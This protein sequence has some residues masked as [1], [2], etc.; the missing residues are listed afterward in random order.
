MVR[1]WEWAQ[2]LH[3]VGKNYLYVNRALGTFPPGRWYCPPEV[4]AITLV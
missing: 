3:Q 4:T 2:G 1:H